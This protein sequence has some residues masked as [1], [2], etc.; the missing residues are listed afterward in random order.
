M[1]KKTAANTT[2]LAAAKRNL[3]SE[4][5]RI[6]CALMNDGRT[7]NGSIHDV[8]QYLFG[9]MPF[10]DAFALLMEGNWDDTFNVQWRGAVLLAADAFIEGNF[11]YP[12]YVVKQLDLLRVQRMARNLFLNGRWNG[13]DMLHIVHVISAYTEPQSDDYFIEGMN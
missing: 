2:F 8:M 3:K 4:N 10:Q 7:N 1:S 5:Y 6:V 12:S 13:K 9:I 11:V